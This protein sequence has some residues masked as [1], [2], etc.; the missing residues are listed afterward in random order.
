MCS[1]VQSYEFPI[2]DPQYFWSE[3]IIQIFLFSPNDVMVGVTINAGQLKCWAVVIFKN[4]DIYYLKFVNTLK[5]KLNKKN[6]FIKNI[7]Y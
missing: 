5:L 2:I 4:I 6:D 7:P 3:E 1:S